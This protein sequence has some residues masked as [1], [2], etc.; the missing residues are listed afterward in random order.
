MITRT[1]SALADG[2]WAAAGSP[3]SGAP[4]VSRCFLAT[5]LGV[6]KTALTGEESRLRRA[7]RAVQRERGRGRILSQSVY[8]PSLG[9]LSRFPC[10]SSLMHVTGRWVRR[11]PTASSGSRAQLTQPPGFQASRLCLRGKTTIPIFSLMPIPPPRPVVLCLC[12]ELVTWGALANNGVCAPPGEIL[13]QL[14]WSRVLAL[15]GH[16]NAT[17]DL[18]VQ[19]GLRTSYNH[20]L[21]EG[22][23]SFAIP[24]PGECLLFFALPSQAKRQSSLCSKLQCSSYLFC[25]EVHSAITL[26]S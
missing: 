10:I 14:I 15:V 21:S 19:L 23:C 17:G 8:S 1:Q 4:P 22:S 2:V 13:S 9:L 11:G 3:I 18:T 5:A 20:Q 7:V 26:L 24:G 12:C 25:K 6:D 16:K